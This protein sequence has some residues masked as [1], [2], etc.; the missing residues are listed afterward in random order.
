MPRYRDK[1]AAIFAAALAQAR[2]AVI[3]LSYAHNEGIDSN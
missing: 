3:R 1:R 2:D